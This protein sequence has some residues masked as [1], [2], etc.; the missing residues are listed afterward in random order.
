MTA[1]EPFTHG[2]SIVIP[3]YQGEKTL[4]G[5]LEEIRPL[6]AGFRTPDGHAA[7]VD[8]VVLSYDRGPDASA[9]VI[10]ELASES[11]WVKPVWL[12]RNYGQHAA[13][14]AGIASSGGD[15]VVTLDEDGQHDPSYIGTL[16]DTALREQADVVYAQP[17]NRPPHGFVRNAASRTSKRALESIFGG[18]KAS[19]FNS[20]RLMLGEIGRSVAAYAGQGVYLDVALGW[21]AGRTTTAPVL[22]RSEGDRVSGYSYRR[23]FAH[24][25]RMIL[26]SGTQGLRAVTVTGLVFFLGG[27]LFALYLIVARFVGGDTPEGWTSQMVLSAIGTGVILVS[28]GIIAE[29]VGV[30]VSVAL[31]KP[32]Y[33]IVRDP[34]AGPLGRTARAE[35]GTPGGE[36]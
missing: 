33:L 25:W 20:Y 17:S 28:L 3:V 1:V 9:R 26:T 8:E 23:L 16:L 29:Y 12:S 34:Q 32:A 24:F 22:L 4:R 7:R 11:A 13:T 31:G 18:G 15:W 27:I 36:H 5:V 21:V 19:H 6:T 10:R 14:L 35:D 30:T 2:I